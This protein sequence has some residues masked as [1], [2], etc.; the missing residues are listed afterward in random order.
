MPVIHLQPS[1]HGAGKF[2]HVVRARQT[3]PL[4]SIPYWHNRSDDEERAIWTLRP[5][6]HAYLEER[7]VSYK[8]WWA[9]IYRDSPEEIFDHRWH[10]EVE[11]P[12]LAMLLKLMWG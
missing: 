7:G 5:E 11:D 9:D 8:I 2:V 6:Y 4:P 10:L 1:E 3:D 12:E